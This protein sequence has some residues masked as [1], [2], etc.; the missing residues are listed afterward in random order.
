[1]ISVFENVCLSAIIFDKKNVLFIDSPHSYFVNYHF[2][3]YLEK[4][5]YDAEE[6]HKFHRYRVHHCKFKY[7]IGRD[8]DEL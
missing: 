3:R 6:K 2:T 4:C 1:M 8:G 7:K 5:A